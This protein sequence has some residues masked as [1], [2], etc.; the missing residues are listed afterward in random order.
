MSLGYAYGSAS[1]AR[2]SDCYALGFRFEEEQGFHPDAGES[3]VMR[4]QGTKVRTLLSVAGWFTMLW[5]APSG[6]VYVS[7]ASGRLYVRPPEPADG[8]IAPP[9]FEQ[10]DLPGVLQGLWG[11]DD[12]HVFVWGRR[13][14]QPVMYVGH[15]RTWRPIAAPGFITGMHGIRPDL[16]FA[17]G[18]A[19]MI[20]RWDGSAWH[21]M[22]SPADKQLSS[23]FVVSADEIYACGHGK[24]LL[25]GSVHGWVRVL[26][27]TAPLRAI[28]KW[29]DGIWVAA[30][31]DE[32]LSL[33]EKGKLVSVK[34][35]L[36]ASQLDARHDLLITC[37][38]MVV[39]SADG[40]KFTG[41]KLDVFERLTKNERPAWER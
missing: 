6:T 41:T 35:N 8:A 26:R 7:D 28:V 33:L 20:A 38:T 29:Q 15:H 32:G 27:H 23:V 24:D 30:G 37:P 18:E 5:Q 21:P 2:S 31:G 16:I 25:Q 3:W 12:D 1:G 17:V 13:G 19:G 4:L 9:D 10:Q 39:S 11:L 22:P 14:D 40:K 34:P 36:K